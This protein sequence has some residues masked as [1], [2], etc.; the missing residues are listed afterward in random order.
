MSLPDRLLL[1]Y[2]GDDFTGST[3]VMEA[4]TSA[5]LRTVLFLQPPTAAELTRFPG[6]RAVGVAGTSRAMSPE[7]M[8]REL[9]PA[10]RSLAALD[11]PLVHY[12]TCST[13]DSSPW[14][15]SIGRALELGQDVLGS[16]WVPMVVGAPVLGRYCAFGNLF[17]RSGWESEVYRLDRHPTMRYHPTTPMDESDLRLVLARQTDRRVALFDLPAL[18]QGAA[19]REARL[20]AV[21]GEGPSGVLFDTV[22]DADLKAIGELVWEEAR[23]RP[24]YAVGSSGVEYALTAHWRAR[25]RLPEPPKLAVEA[26]EQL[27]VVSGSCSPVTARQIA[28]A[29]EHGFEE[30]PLS[31]ERL[32]DPAEAE[33]ERARAVARAVEAA[34]RG[35]SVILH[36]SRGPDDPRVAATLQRLEGESGRTAAILGDALG[37]ILAEVLR[38]TGLRRAATTGGDSSSYIARALGAQAL[39]MAAPCAPGS[40]LCRVT[41]PGEPYDGCEIVFKGGQVGTS[42]FFLRAM[43]GSR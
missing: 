8:D 43:S 20:Q 16:P 25:G 18:Q 6:V 22:S 30:V 13:F 5:G 28:C 31:G 21:L 9:P 3:D 10:F 38:A 2:Y 32:V 26:V 42:D 36:T 34:R 37:R 15:G 1:A 23:E 19:H 41:A 35:R 7:E 17:A 39:E 12:K 33:A 4:L 11:A 24:L 27:V 14:I 29:L 40:P